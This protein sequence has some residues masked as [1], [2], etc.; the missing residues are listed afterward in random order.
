MYVCVKRLD[1]S[2]LEGA[3]RML[4]A[5][6]KR[7]DSIVSMDQGSCISFSKGTFSPYLFCIKHI[8]HFCYQIVSIPPLSVGFFFVCFSFF[9]V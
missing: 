1:V 4:W 3:M 2:L 6:I 8:V 9:E 7:D 5:H